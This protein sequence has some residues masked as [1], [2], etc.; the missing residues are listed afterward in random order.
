MAP[1][2]PPPAPP[3][4]GERPPDG[5]GRRGAIVPGLVLI[6]IG[7]ILLAQQFYPELAIGRLWPVILIVI[8]LGIIFRRR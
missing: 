5:D 4:T 7:A 2:Q 6:T 8:G 1:P 3:A